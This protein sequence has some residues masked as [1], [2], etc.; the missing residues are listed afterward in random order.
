MFPEVNSILGYFLS[1]PTR[2]V[3]LR[4]LARQTE[5][6]PAG[7]LKAVR[8]LVQKGILIEKKTR[9]VTNLRANVESPLWIP[10]KRVYNLYSI[11]A[12]GLV[13]AL[14]DTY[15]EPAALVLFGSYA[16][17]DDTEESD[18]DIAVVTRIEAAFGRKSFEKSLGRHINIIELELSKAKGEFIE[19]LVNG[20]VLRGHLALP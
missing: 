6:S 4:E 16:R 10:L 14:S 20:I 1:H 12:C 15:E 3:H 2:Q 19:S 11:Y 9:A 13:E 7:A 17:G 18:I 8:K 5:F